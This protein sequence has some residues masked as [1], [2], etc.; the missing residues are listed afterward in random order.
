MPTKIFSIQ[1]K[2]KADMAA[3]E[4][5]I[6][7]LLGGEQSKCALIRSHDFLALRLRALYRRSKDAPALVVYG[8]GLK[9]TLDSDNVGAVSLLDPETIEPAE[10]PAVLGK[11]RGPS[12]VD[13]E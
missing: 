11:R 1:I 3:L 13:P 8:E 7:T 9:I 6:T 2:T 4:D 10:D 5:T 12:A